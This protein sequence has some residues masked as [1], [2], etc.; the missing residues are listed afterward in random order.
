MTT[1]ILIVLLAATVGILVFLAMRLRDAE[2][3]RTEL[4]N[5]FRGVVDVERE[6]DRIIAETESERTR[7]RAEAAEA[8]ARIVEEAERDRAHVQAETTR[9]AGERESMQRE[10]QEI[11]TALKLLRAEHALLDEEANLR[12]F[13]YYE[14]RW[15]LEN[16]ERYAARLDQVRAAQKALLQAGEAAVCSVPWTVNGSKVEGKKMTTRTLKVLLRAF[17]GECDAAIAKVRYNNFHVMEARIIKAFDAINKLGEVQSCSIT[18]RYRELRLD[19]LSLSHEYQE[20]LQEEKEEQR[21]V[22][23]QMR[24]E[25]VAQR[26]LEKARLDA[27]KEEKRYETALAKARAEVADAQG[28]KQT[29]L[30]GQIEELQRRLDE[31]HANKERAIARAQMTRSGH[32]YVIS[33]LGSFGEHVYKIGM[34]RRLDPQ[35]RIREL[36]DASVPFQFDVHAV[37]FSED[38]P[39]LENALHRLFRNRRINW[40]N[41][42]KEFF[43]VTLTEIEAAVHQHDAKVEFLHFPEAEEYRKTLSIIREEHERQ[44]S[45]ETEFFLQR[46]LKIV[47]E[48][49]LPVA[50]AA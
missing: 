46:G 38:A 20:K 11:Q 9:L 45:R 33:N 17:N 37:I 7:I 36:G 27:E 47:A 49:D 50:A 39:G 40:V 6:K 22:R 31:A 3:R 21:R 5:R 16:S 15:E 44:P 23:E 25:E 29:R 42:R 18:R 19:E 35:D 8:S 43:H 14:P 1:I 26:E 41:D 12:S 48:A 28:E 13:G 30:L 10:T 2:T 24:E 34:T 32:V 4:E